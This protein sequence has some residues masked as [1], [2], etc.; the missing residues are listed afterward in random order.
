[1]FIKVL[2]LILGLKPAKYRCSIPECDEPSSSFDIS[3]K[4]TGT[5]EPRAIF[6]N[7]LA[8]ELDFCKVRPLNSS[9]IHVPGKCTIDDFDMTGDPVLCDARKMNVIYEGFA[10]KSTIVTEFNLFCNEEYKA[11]YSMIPYV[12]YT[13]L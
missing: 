12:K 9:M 3:S 8:G 10:M 13:K 1:M 11:R 7:G 4:N 6:M 2:I 5:L